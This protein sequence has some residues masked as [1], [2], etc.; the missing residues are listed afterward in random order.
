MAKPEILPPEAAIEQLMRS[1]DLGDLMR[2]VI[3]D[4]QRANGVSD[5][6]V[7][8]RVAGVLAR[9][10]AADPNPMRRARFIMRMYDQFAASVEQIAE[11]NLRD[12][13]IAGAA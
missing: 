12:M 2:G 10:V 9:L 4:W 8:H 3:N 6:E 5:A 11:R 13:P 7:A 1:R